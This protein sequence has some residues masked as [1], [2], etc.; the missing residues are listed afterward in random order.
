MG[1]PCEHV[2]QLPPF[3]LHRLHLP[4]AN[5]RVGERGPDPGAGFLHLHVLPQSCLCQL[6]HL[7][8]P[9]GLRNKV[10]WPAAGACRTLGRQRHHLTIPCLS[11]VLPPPA[12]C[13]T[14]PGPCTPSC[15]QALA[16]PRPE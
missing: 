4:H 12:C 6:E 9:A 8:H 13:Q 5:V 1:H 2:V 10:R 11:P 3:R 16:C 14:S 15:H 7:T